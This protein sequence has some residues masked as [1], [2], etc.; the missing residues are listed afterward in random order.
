MCYT[1]F[2]KFYNKEYL[3]RLLEAG[4][5]I[6]AMD[7][8][9]DKNYRDRYFERGHWGTK[10][11]QTFVMLLSW[12]VLVI[13]ITITVATYLAYRT[14]G[15]HGHFFWHYAE[16]FQELNFL[17]IFLTFALGVIAVFCFAMGYIQ[18]Q[19]SRGLVAKWPMFDMAKNRW[20]RHRAEQ[21]MTAR[22]GDE[23]YR[24]SRR[25]YT[26]QPEQN[27]KKNQLKQIVNGEEGKE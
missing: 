15:R 7:V 14:R 20:E 1:L 21:F 27:L 13:P 4:Y 8:K 12:V 16:G 17:M 11:W 3:N 6:I 10:I 23:A 26:V 2:L 5:P 22:F 9:N 25:N 18:L 24:Q 19:R